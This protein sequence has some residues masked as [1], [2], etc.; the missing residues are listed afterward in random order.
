ME[1]ERLRQLW[2]GLNKKRDAG[3]DLSGVTLGMLNDF[4]ILLYKY[5]ITKTPSMSV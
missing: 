3:H 2:E 5:K 4:S 1:D